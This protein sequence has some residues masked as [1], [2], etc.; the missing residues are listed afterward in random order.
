MAT[1]SPSSQP[2]APSSR[3][4]VAL[5]LYK[6]LGANFDDEGTRQALKT[7][8]ELYGPSSTVHP[9]ARK[10]AK[11]STDSESDEDEEQDTSAAQN[12]FANTFLGSA[13]V[14]G[15]TA[16]RARKHLRRD[17]ENKLTE[18]SHKFLKAFGEVDQI[19][20]DILQE[21]VA[22]MRMHCD[23]AESHLEET[24]ESCK[25]LL[26]RAGSLRQ[27]RQDIATKQS[28]VMLFLSRFTLTDEE[29]EILT[30]RDVQVGRRFFDIMDKTGGIRQDCQV[31]M[32]GEDGPT[33]IGLDIMSST[34]SNLEQA[35]EKIFRWCSFEFRQMGRET[36]V[37]VSPT[38]REAVTRLRQRQEFLSEALAFLSHSRQTV[39][40]NAFMNALTHGGP[41]GLPRPI[42]LHAHDPMRYIG[43]MLAWIHQTIAAEREFLESLFDVKS[44]MRMV[45]SVRKFGKN[46]EEE[47]IQELMDAAMSKVSVPLKVRVQQ[48]I[49]SQESSIVSFKIANLLQFYMLTMHRTIG[50]D[51][52]LSQTLNEIT[53]VAYKSFFD[54][55]AAHGKALLGVA[56]DL[57]GLEV[58]PPLAIQDHGQVLRE[59]VVVYESSLLEDESPE[60]QAAGAKQI[61]DSMVDPAVEM[62]LTASEEKR[63]L[64]QRWDYR[65]FVLNCL[66]YIK[67]V[68]EPYMFTKEKQEVIDKLIDERVEDLVYDHY[69]NL[70]RDAGLYEAF[71]VC[72]NHTSGE[73]M[74]RIP[75]TEPE[76]LQTALHQF[77]VWLSDI[78]VVHSPRLA[79]L[80]IQSLNNRVH[81][82]ALERLANSYQRLCEEVKKPS[83]RYEAAATL[84]GSERPF[85]QVR[86]LWQ[87]FGLQDQEGA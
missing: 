30:S 15:D 28:I 72:F 42:E 4:P 83:N 74:S 58:I 8:S 51:A 78:G 57:D 27:E 11:P 80:T 9:T 79:R 13:N 43:D 36:Q 69:Q 44:D 10:P 45:G 19:Q 63:K 77:S 17:V 82:A 68:I 31:L 38:M 47:W 73:P 62:C 50:E 16:A 12:T 48:T 39:L 5:R 53:D 23:E 59:I 61:I 84:L 33:Q 81:H 20:L 25:S 49:R 54:S 71:A 14:P 24:N 22:T 76:A 52:L 65:V 32:A 29:T 86:L 75:A 7:V 37:E 70:T 64:R 1:A 35:Y 34:S 60:Q 26:E 3:N 18:A 87:I 85:G 6:I 40:L 41:G 21:H 56:L 46:E 55:T 66:T 2:A 67:S